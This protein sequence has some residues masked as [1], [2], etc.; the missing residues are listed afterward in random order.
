MKTRLD[1]S[2]TAL[3]RKGQPASRALRP[4]LSMQ[5][6]GGFPV[7]ARDVQ[8]VTEKWR[9]HCLRC[10]RVWEELY[11]ARYSG[12]AVSWWLS[13]IPAQPPWIDPACLGCSSLQ[14]KVLPS[15]LVV[16]RGAV[17]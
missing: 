15:G 17:K 2:L 4:G 13:G 3:P 10:L 1:A 12:D 6:A 5:A 9:F 7:R 8:R 16:H 14:V 11:Q